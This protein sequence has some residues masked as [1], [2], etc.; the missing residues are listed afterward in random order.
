ME[1]IPAVDVVTGSFGT[2]QVPIPLVSKDA[3]HGPCGSWHGLSW[4]TGHW[5]HEQRRSNLAPR[6]LG[7]TQLED[8]CGWKSGCEGPGASCDRCQRSRSLL[9]LTTYIQG[10]RAR[11]LAEILQEQ[12]RPCSSECSF[13][14][15]EKTWNEHTNQIKSA[16]IWI[17]YVTRFL[18]I[19]ILYIYIIYIMFLAGPLQSVEVEK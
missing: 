7:G 2:L 17:H 18:Y 10:Y 3:G 8:V 16:W 11:V 1:N 19:Y 12:S 5:P 4:S 9:S 15:I 14:C 13:L 6:P